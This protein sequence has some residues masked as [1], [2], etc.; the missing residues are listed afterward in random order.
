MITTRILLIINF[1]TFLSLNLRNFSNNSFSNLNQGSNLVC[2]RFLNETTT[3]S[4]EE[5]KDRSPTTDVAEKQ[6]DQ[7]SPDASGVSQGEQTLT[8]TNGK[9][10]QLTTQS[11]PKGPEHTSDP[12]A[13]S[14]N[15]SADAKPPSNEGDGSSGQVTKVETSVPKQENQNGQS[16]TIAPDK[17][18]E[19]PSPPSDLSKQTTEVKPPQTEEESGGEV[20]TGDAATSVS[21]TQEV[22]VSE[23]VQTDVDGHSKGN[24]ST[25]D[26][27]NELTNP[28][29]KEKLDGESPE[30]VETP[31][32]I[33]DDYASV[34]SED[35]IERT[36]EE[37]TPR[38]SHGTEYNNF[39]NF[40]RLRKYKL[41]KNASHMNE[42][43]EME[44]ENEKSCTHNNGGCGDDKI[45]IT[46]ANN[47]IACIC[48]EGYLVGNQCVISQSSSLKPLLSLVIY[49]IISLIIIN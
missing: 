48:K 5:N 12:T 9:T 16:Q 33:E 11:D 40:N 4:V 3:G 27:N 41:G 43:K 17:A 34:H 14:P 49:T 1:F 25:G 13:S 28:T 10:T 39:D 42:L 38:N 18:P 24:S 7:V 29:N 23:H 8:A 44:E 32:V 6:A 47:N 30:L 15:P 21:K 35:R 31:T 22:E 2:N 20:K 37:D 45:C 26:S 36:I 46:T 19:V